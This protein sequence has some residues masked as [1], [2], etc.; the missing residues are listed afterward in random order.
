MPAEFT[1]GRGSE[2]AVQ[3]TGDGVS[4]RHCR[5]EMRR[6]RLFVVDLDSTNGTHVNGTR[7]PPLEPI[8]LHP[9]DRVL[10]GKAVQ[11][12]LNRIVKMISGYQSADTAQSVGG[13]RPP[14]RTQ[15][16]SHNPQHVTQQPVPQ[17]ASGANPDPRQGDRTQG[18][19]QRQ[20]VAIRKEFEAMRS[21][22]GP[23][24]LV[25][26]L[27]Y[28]GFLPGFITNIIYLNQARA[29]RTHIGRNPSGYGCLVTLMVLASISLAVGFIFF[30]IMLSMGMILL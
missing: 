17:P 22:V 30:M 9:G 29:T 6:N 5:F 23:A 16:V 7:I 8:E 12:D 15:P 13:H 27:Y 1:A 26:F 19:E 20:A 3:L 21:Y 11:L 14:E 10:L 28:I 24:W 2:N 25:F 18:A 4:R